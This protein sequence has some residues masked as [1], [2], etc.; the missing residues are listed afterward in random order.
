MKLALINTPSLHSYG[1][2]RTGH[3]CSFPLGL[4]YIASYVRQKGHEVRIFDP[5]PYRQSVPQLL[6]ALHEFKPDLVGLTCV[7][8]NFMLACD[9]VRSIKALH[10]CI[11]IVGGVHVNALPR[12]TL[13]ALPELDAIIFGE[14][15]IPV[16]EIAEEFDRKGRVDFNKIHNSAFISKQTVS[17]YES[18]RIDYINNL[19][20]LPYPARDLVDLSL[21]R[22]H[23]QF[24]RGVK[25]ATILSSR[26]CPSKCTFC[27]NI[28]TGRKFRPNSPEYFVQELG[29]LVKEYNIRHFHV[30]DDCFTANSKRVEAIC[31]LILQ[32]HL[33][34]SW[35]I[36]GRVNQLLDE[37]IIKKMK[38][39]GCVNVLL[40]IETGD[41]EINRQMKKGTTLEM[42]EKSCSLLRSNRIQYLNSFMIGNESDT[43]QTVEKTIQFAIKLKS[44]MVGFNMLIPFPG[45]ALFRK[46]YSDFDSPGTNWN[47][48]CAVADELPF[49]PRHTTLSKSEIMRLTSHAYWRFYMR[50][51]QL[52]RILGSC[53]NFG[54]LISFLKGSIGLFRQTVSWAVQ[55]HSKW[56]FFK[57]GKKGS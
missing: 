13:A 25:S 12:S 24:S 37:Q 2:I 27:A 5:E 50:P 35:F 29:H 41:Q 48:W 53:T 9:L 23:P 19:D 8:P 11:V 55:S 42:A 54:T 44:T 6:R 34:I 40:G 31:D 46:Y 10:S 7:T 21:Y 14:G 47:N 22:L 38:M 45:T 32:K 56:L 52:L 30:V 28:C 3:N 33:K 39:A 51:A 57:Q 43:R 49:E 26:G 16:L 1:K 15:E 4:G 17:Y 20:I 36:F 18:E